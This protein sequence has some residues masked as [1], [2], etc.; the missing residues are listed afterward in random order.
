MGPVKSEASI[1]DRRSRPVSLWL[2][3]AKSQSQGW[4]AV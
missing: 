2:E 3:D 4:E 1:G